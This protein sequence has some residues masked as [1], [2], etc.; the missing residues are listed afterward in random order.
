MVLSWQL[1]S[2]SIAHHDMSVVEMC[3]VSAHNHSHLEQ[4][5]VMRRCATVGS[6]LLRLIIE[7]DASSS[8]WCCVWQVP[9][10]TLA[11]T[12]GGV[13]LVLMLGL[14]LARCTRSRRT[15]SCASWLSSFSRPLWLLHAQVVPV[16]CQ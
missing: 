8:F 10:W 15:D 1:Q 9:L 12:A 6:T 11:V 4:V 16:L 14:C 7:L 5:C 3:Y 13:M 2:H